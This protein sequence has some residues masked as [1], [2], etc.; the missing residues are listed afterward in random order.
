VI[1]IDHGRMI[2]DDTASALKSALG[3]L[4]SLEL[5]SEADAMAAAAHAD[6]IPGAHVTVSD[7]RVTVRAPYGRDAAPGLVAGLAA[8]GTPVTRMEVVGPTLDDVFLNLTG[9]SLREA[10]EDAATTDT[11]AEHEGAAA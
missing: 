1:V 8:A 10:A 9:R 6:R 7:A 4:V 3:D 2:A 5:G 11:H